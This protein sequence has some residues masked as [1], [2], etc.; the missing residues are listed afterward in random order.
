M[1]VAASTR[2]ET[3]PACLRPTE[4]KSCSSLVRWSTSNMLEFFES[5]PDEPQRSLRA[6]LSTGECECLTFN[7]DTFHIYFHFARNW[8]SSA[9]LLE[10]CLAFH[11]NLHI[12]MLPEKHVC[13]CRKFLERSLQERYGCP[14]CSYNTPVYLV[15]FNCRELSNSPNQISVFDLRTNHIFS[16]P[17]RKRKEMGE[18]YAVCSYHC[19]QV[20]YVVISG[21]CGKSPGKLHRYDVVMDKWDIKH[22]LNHE[23][24]GHVMCSAGGQIYLIGGRE[25]ATAEVWDWKSKGSVDI[26]RLPVAVANIAHVV[27]DNHIFLFGGESEHGNV[28][29][30]QC[31]DLKT[32]NISRLKNL[33]CKC[34]G[35]QATAHNNEIYIAT[36]QGHMI[37]Y[38]P[39][40]GNSDLCAPQ[41]FNRK[42]F[43]M[44]A[45]DDSIFLLGGV[46]A[47]R[48]TNS[49][50]VL[51][52]YSTTHDRWEKSGTFIRPMPVFANCAVEFPKACPIIPFMSSL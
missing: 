44:F 39:L 50:C 20:P 43:A 15:L 45:E 51:C 8:N 25:S 52:K 35:G 13:D 10:A 11:S 3:Y 40:T 46:C 36:H 14:N 33:P 19:D 5:I 30:V 41:P 9:S 42:H 23:R 28:S 16:V 4:S 22:D 7:K 21:G 2:T 26:G 31:I 49:S 37:R 6:F 48:K 12:S 1:A 18:G 38:D 34:S 47:D 27:F 29:A 17:A 24:S 32:N